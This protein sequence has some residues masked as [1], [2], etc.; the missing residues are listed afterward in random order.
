[1]Q[2]DVRRVLE[3]VDRLPSATP[4]TWAGAPLTPI[5]V[6]AQVG[7]PIARAGEKRSHA[8]S[9]GGPAADA[10]SLRVDLPPQGNRQ[11]YKRLCRPLRVPVS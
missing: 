7:G 8:S 4:E 1:M 11:G 9:E 2:T 5:A 3:D 10:A 6:P